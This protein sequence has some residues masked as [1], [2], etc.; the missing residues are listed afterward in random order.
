MLNN[1]FE[2]G[3][4]LHKIIWRYLS[5][6]PF[7]LISLLFFAFTAFVIIRYTTPLYDTL[8]K[9][10]ILDKSQDSEMAL[11]TA[12]TIFNRSMINIDNEVGRL[13]SYL[14]NSK[15]SEKLNSNIKFYSEGKIL[16]V[17]QHKSEFFN[18][19]SFDVNIDITTIS[20]RISFELIFSNSGLS[21][22]SIDKSGSIVN[23]H[24][25]ESFSTYAKNHSLPFDI[26]VR[27]A[28]LLKDKG[29]INKRI[30]FEDF[31]SEVLSLISILDIT[32][33]KI[34]ISSYQS[35]DQILISMQYENKLIAQDYVN[36]LISAFDLDG[37]LERQL[38]YKNTINFVESRS[39]F[40]EKELSIIENKKQEFKKL[41]KLTDLKFNA[42]YASNLMGNYNSELFALRSQKELIILLQEEININNYSLLPI[43]FG[44]NDQSINGLISQFN[45]LVKERDRFLNSG[46]GLKNP[47]V[48]NI[49]SQ[50]DNIYENIRLSIDSYE[51]SLAIQID[52]I[53]EKESELDNFYSDVPENEKIL[54]S[55]ERELEI[56]EA[57]FLLLLQKKEEASVNF[58]VVKPTIKIIDNAMSSN[59]SVF[60]KKINIIIICI[61][62]GIM[63]PILILF[64]WFSLDNK[65]HVKDDLKF[66][67]LPLLAEIPFL[68]DSENFLIKDLKVSSRSNLTESIRMLLA[69]L[70]YVLK[71]QTANTILI[72]STIK[73]EGKTL[74]STHLSKIISYRNDK[75]LLVGTDLRNPQIHSYLGIDKYASKG[76]ADYLFMN[77]LD[78]KDIVIKNDNL[79]II[80]SGVIPPNPA[81]LLNSKKYSKFLEEAKKI[82]DYIIIDSAPC[83]PVADTVQKASLYDTTICVVRANH[84]NKDT[85]QYLDENK[86]LFNNLSLVLNA[87]GNS[88]AY[89]YKYGYQYGYNYG[90]GYGYGSSS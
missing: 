14:I 55:I 85:L 19:Y 87:V 2:E 38:E 45:L 63:I 62:L 1:N 43:N 7:I 48:S 73:G 88:S 37:I 33:P 41:N 9:I 60:P 21:I 56:K 64:I 23:S 68:K 52:A 29:V 32:N 57:L 50:L 6:W 61:L 80:L 72:T 54:R 59:S 83:L 75:V 69:N 3:A 20:E 76:I 18:D 8:A 79:D 40:L 11:P 51:K 70:S 67:N 35:S 66:L 22:K 17:R 81:E 71:K 30:V 12:M 58:A 53:I 28:D 10:E 4:S 82:Y 5:F 46:A 31:E 78:W 15:V 13:K 34:N 84:S 86:K 16:L 27:D 90:Y 49:S 42:D 74:V 25:F 89:G 39:K 65:I 77:D 24:S 26:E 36:S 47:L 44:L